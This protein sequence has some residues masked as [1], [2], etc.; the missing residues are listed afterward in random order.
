MPLT[1]ELLFDFKE[2]FGEHSGENIAESVWVTMKL[3][4]TFGND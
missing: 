1:K 2:L 4:N 3:Y